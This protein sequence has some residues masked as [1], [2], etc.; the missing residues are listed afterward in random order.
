VCIG[1]VPG[2]H[3]PKERVTKWFEAERPPGSFQGGEEEVE[4]RKR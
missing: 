3:R 2:K 4:R 1:T